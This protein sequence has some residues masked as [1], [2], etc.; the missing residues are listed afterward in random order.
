MPNTEPEAGLTNEVRRLLGD[1]RDAL[2]EV[3]EL[4]RRVDDLTRDVSTIEVLL[5]PMKL[6]Q[7]EKWRR[8][9][10]ER[11]EDWAFVET[12]NGTQVLAVDQPSKRGQREPWAAV[13]H[14][15]V[16]TRLVSW[17]LFHAWRSSDLLTDT[18]SSVNRW[19]LYTAAVSARALIESTGCLL[20]EAKRVGAAWATAKAAEGGGAVRAEAVYRDLAPILTRAG[21]GS[22]MKAAPDA[23]KATNVQTY[24]DK[25]AKD[26]GDQRFADWYDWLSDAAHPAF[27]ARIAFSSD[28]LVHDRRAVVERYYVRSP[29]HIQGKGRTQDFEHPIFQKSVDALIACA[30]V[31]DQ[32]LEQSLHIVDDFGLTT[33]APTYTLRSYWRDFVPTQGRLP[34]PWGRGTWNTCGHQWGAP[35]PRVGVPRAT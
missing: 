12:K 28:P 8:Q 31:V 24:V 19:R 7:A 18:L 33:E 32:V 1:R 5:L 20:Y 26:A 34:C 17:W 35:A 4:I 13:V 10:L 2:V 27:G 9:A 23:L 29:M 14:P 6:N 15:T 30:Q 21:L 11:R 3:E 22:R 25:L 16:H